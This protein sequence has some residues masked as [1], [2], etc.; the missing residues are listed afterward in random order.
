MSI[1]KRAITATGIENPI[2][3]KK[4]ILTERSKVALMNIE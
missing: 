2:S 4:K 3:L 1:L